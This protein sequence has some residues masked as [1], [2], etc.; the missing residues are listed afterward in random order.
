MTLAEQ[1]LAIGNLSELHTD[2]IT[3]LVA[4]VNEIYDGAVKSIVK[5][6]TTGLIDTYTITYGDDTTATFTVTN[7]AKG[8]TGEK[9]DKG[10]AGEKGD[11]YVLTEDDK[12]EVA[13]T[14]KAEVPLVKVAEQPTFAND[15]TEFTD[16]STIYVL[17]DNY[18]WAYMRK[19]VP[20]EEER[21]P[22]FTNLVA[23]DFSNVEFDKRISSSENTSTFVG[24]ICLPAY[25]DI[26]GGDIIRI[27][28]TESNF[29]TNYTRILFYNTL[30]ARLNN[31]DTVP[32]ND[33]YIKDNITFADDVMTLTIP[34]TINGG[35]PLKNANQSI[36]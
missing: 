23:S 10:D 25:M 32:I 22:N 8:D 31:Q 28:L 2:N 7:G 17:P 5:T 26:V 16:T 36:H 15:N 34:E 6:D 1:I 33:I 9:G 13:D 11:S 35:P 24:G 4:A 3:T 21:I 18:M 20:T 19:S 14:V 12:Q 27:K 29:S 30:N